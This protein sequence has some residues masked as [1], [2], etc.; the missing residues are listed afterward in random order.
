ARYARAGARQKATGCQFLAGLY[1]KR[2][3]S[4]VAALRATLRR[5]LGLPPAPEDHDE[6]VP[7]TD[8]DASDPEDE[9][10]DPGAAL[11]A[12]PPALTGPESDLATRL[13]EAAEAVPA[14]QDAKL[15]ALSRLMSGPLAGQKVVVFTEYRD[16]LRPAARRLQAEGV[17]Y[18]SFHGDTPD[19]QRRAAVTS[20]IH[21]PGVRV[22]LATDAA[23]EGQNLQH[24][25]HHLVHLDVPWNPN[26][27]AQRNG[28]VDR[29]GQDQ[30]PEIWVLVAADR[31]RGQGRPEYRAL[32]LVVEKLRLI[33]DELGSVSPVLPGTSA[34]VA[35]VLARARSDAERRIHELL[36]D[37]S[38]RAAQAELSRLSA[39]NR[40]EIDEAERYVATLGSVDDFEA[41]VGGLLRT[42][43]HGWDDGGRIEAL[44]DGLVRVRVPTRLRAELG[45]AVISLATFRRDVALADQDGEPDSVPEFLSPAHP[46]VAAVLRRLR[47]DAADPHFPHRFDVEAGLPE[48]LVCS[49]AVRFVDGEGR[50]LEERLEAVEVSL[51]GG[52]SADATDDQDRLGLSRPSSTGRPDARAVERWQAAFPALA[53]IAR[54]EAS[55][56][57]EARREELVALAEELWEDE[58]EVLGLWRS[59]QA[60]RIERIVFGTETSVTFEQ[61]AAHETMTA[62]LEAE[63]HARRGALRDR[64]AVRVAGL[65]L[66]GG[67]LIVAP[68]GAAERGQR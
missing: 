41:E 24:G 33:H 55:R 6:A 2:F 67:R 61:A 10:L 26:R 7:L 25:A 40:R 63:H 49:F 50:T 43:F 13:L 62:R 1:R 66:I 57:V 14:G 9:I 68:A 29:Y 53:P 48:G 35:E 30:R 38:A 31:K 32:E 5:R 45:P 46:L 23:S 16:T 39:R 37:P 64:S 47:D 21:D 28:R 52:A 3:G 58:L 51:E 27:Y 12:P 56:R 15:R 60:R 8:T 36:D 34:N 22:F 19:A 11:G 44:G 54:A 65:E 17:S 42:A 18:V 59:D 4:S 20:F